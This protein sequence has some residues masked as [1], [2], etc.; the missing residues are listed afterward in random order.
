MFITLKLVASQL[1]QLELFGKA[2][3]LFLVSR[4]VEQF[5]LMDYDSIVFFGRTDPLSL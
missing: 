4:S 5:F 1:Q 2:N 3:Y